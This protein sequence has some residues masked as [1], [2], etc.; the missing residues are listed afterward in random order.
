MSAGSSSEFDARFA[1]AMTE[2]GQ[3]YRI[4]PTALVDTAWARGRAIRR[5]RRA[6][7]VVAGVAAVA[8]VGVG[9]TAVV[10]AFDGARP[11]GAAHGAAAQ[12]SGPEFQAMLTELLPQGTVEVGQAQGTEADPA[13]LRLTVDDGHGAAQFL[14]WITRGGK[15]AQGCPAYLGEDTCTETET[16]A[17]QVVV[18][19]AGARSGEPAGSKTWSAVLYTKDG[20]Q[21]MLQEWNRKPLEQGTPITRADPPLTAAQLT[22]VVTDPRWKRVEAALSSQ[23]PGASTPTAVAP[24][25]TWPS[26]GVAVPAPSGPADALR[27]AVAS[28]VPVGPT[29]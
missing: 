15:G 2:A 29:E 9:G 23:K 19:Q 4:E 27:S 11:V 21:L 3:A 18:Y 16:E 14:F 8:L 10:G 28:A 7:V 1:E 20:Y 22:A 17:G 6:S 24:S 5:R 26:G 25:L 13:Q 12:V